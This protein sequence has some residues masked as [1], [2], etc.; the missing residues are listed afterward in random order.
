MD[1]SIHDALEAGF[2]KILFI[3]RR[4]IEKAFREAIGDRMEKL[5][6]R[7]GVEVGYAFQELSDLPE[8]VE[9]PEGRPSPGGP[10]R[11]CWPAGGSFRN[12]LR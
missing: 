5:C 2:N 7:L 6:R 11:Q 12:L 10:D 8:G 3:I 4:D 9:L 1:Y